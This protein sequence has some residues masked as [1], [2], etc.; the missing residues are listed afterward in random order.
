[1]SQLYYKITQIRSII[2]MPPL[3][4]KN[5][6]A[7]GLTRRFQTVYQQVS[8]SAANRLVK[9]KELVTVQLVNEKKLPQE[10]N[11]ERKFPKGFKLVKATLSLWPYY[12]YIDNTI[13][14]MPD[15]LFKDDEKYAAV[16][17]KSPPILS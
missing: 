4:K 11:E 8:P 7:L 3:V 10:M 17:D 1:M 16:P 14:T 13:F 2:G 15:T 12:L 6:R 9:C 5:L